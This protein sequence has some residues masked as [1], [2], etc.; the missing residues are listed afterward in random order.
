MSLP[1]PPDPMTSTPFRPSPPAD[2]GFVGLAPFLRT[3]IAGGDLRAASQRCLD[4]VAEHPGDCA[5]WMNL[6]TALL[7]LDQREVGLQIQAEALAIERVYRLPAARQPAALRLLMFMAPGDL[8]ANMPLDCL[9]EGSDIELILYYVQ[10]GAPL[11]APVPEHDAAIVAL[12]ESDDN[13]P[14][15]AELAAALA[16]WPRP[17]LNR[18]ERIPAVG[19]S[20]ASELLRDAPGV[21]MPPTWRVARAALAGEASGLAGEASGLAAAFP[22]IVRPVDSHAGRDLARIDD[23]A[24]LAAY[25]ARVGDAEFFLSPF[26][27]YRGADGLFRK[28]R[29]AL[30]DGVPYA[31]HM[32]ISAHWMIHYVNAGMYEDAGKRAEEERFMAD[33]PA[34]ARRHHEAL[35]AIQRRI[36]LDYLCLDCGETGD[37]ELLIFEVDHAMV[38]H[39]MDDETLFP[40]KRG[41]I[42]KLQAAFR[43]FL[44]RVAKG[45]R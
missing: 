8:S 38:V 15:L 41:P 17:L 6:A 35:A 37:G 5:S 43:D 13:A 45:K 20:R 24:A 34:F 16:D 27:D 19:R 33:F 12:S 40:Y 23:A 9:L 42:G 36:G 10:A 31:C 32:A 14:L 21:R 3:S 25:L 11:A 39:A 7:S 18:P 26:V 29:I 1:R 22:L 44:L 4:A 28:F 30:V 2:A